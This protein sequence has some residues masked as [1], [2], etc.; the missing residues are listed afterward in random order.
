MGP[1]R[2]GRRSSVAGLCQAVA[3]AGLGQ[4]HLRVGRL[5]LELGPQL[6]HV[7]A[8]VVRVVGE[9]RAP[10]VGQQL[11]VVTTCPAWRTRRASS[12]YSVG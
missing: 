10:H 9:L 3:H 2:P 1:R 5:G 8:Q 6:R 12:R 11:A 7:Q 4:Q